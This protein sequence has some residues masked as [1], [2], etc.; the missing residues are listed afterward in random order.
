MGN[1]PVPEDRYEAMMNLPLEEKL[2]LTLEPILDFDIN[3]L[4]SWVADINPEFLNLGADSKG[5]GL[6]EPTVEKIM[7][8]TNKLHE[9]GIE[10]REKH[11]LNRLKER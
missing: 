8:L 3:V 1:A 9:I 4:A 10:L 7:A 6:Q 2:F 11:N 5:N